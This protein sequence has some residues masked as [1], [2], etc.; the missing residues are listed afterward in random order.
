MIY[1]GTKESTTTTEVLAEE[2]EH[3]DYNN[4]N[5]GVGRGYKT[6]PRDRR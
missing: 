2:D 4:D 1:N 5:G 3:G 6:G